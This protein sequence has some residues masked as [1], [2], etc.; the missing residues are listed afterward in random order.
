MQVIRRWLVLRFWFFTHLRFKPP[1]RLLIAPQDIRTSDPTIATDI[2]AGYFAFGGKIV[3][4]H[5]RSPFELDPSSETWVRALASFSWLRHLRAADT[6]L[7]HANARALVDDFLIMFG[8]P[9]SVP[10]WEPEVAA[11][12]MLAW[13]SQSPIILDGTDH[14][15]YR[16]FMKGL[17]K[18]QIYLQARIYEGLKG[19][20]RLL[21]ALALAEFVLCVDGPAKV[22]SRYLKIFM[23]ELEKQILPDG[24]HI[25]RNPQNLVDLLLDLLPLRQAFG[26]R[27]LQTP[28]QLLNVIDRAMPMLRLYR[29]GDGTL[30]LFHGMG[31]TLPE[32]L[33][34]VLAYDD[35]R[36]TAMTNAR[37]TG[38]QRIEA[39]DTILI[40]DT[41][42]P[43]P[44]IFSNRANASCLAF[45]FSAGNHRIII[46]C[47][48]PD[49]GRA[50]A[51]AA[52]RTSAAQSTLT[53]NDTS[54][55]R[56][57][58]QLGHWS[59]LGNQIL[60]G[61]QKVEVTRS[62]L[63]EGTEL[64]AAHDGYEER[65]GWHHQREIM[66]FENATML[67]GTDILKLKSKKKLPKHYPF[68]IRFHIHPH[69]KIR[70]LK[71]K[72]WA[73]CVLPNRRRW[74]FS[75][76]Y[77]KLSIEESIFFAAM[78][79]PRKTSQIVIEANTEQ[80][81][82]ISWSLQEIARKN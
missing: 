43:P 38:Y 6:A 15:F 21:I 9:S 59:F 77:S 54:S 42:V 20:T 18:L 49:P 57:S 33:A 74:L 40:M 60:S 13:L 26:A 72:Q 65:F 78:D 62:T 50:G 75:T 24:G 66:V 23:D 39:K 1:Q 80:T 51:L 27:G 11:R 41:G 71:N 45:E 25:S 31:V 16:R 63:T 82:R 14:A 5:G 64:S 4:A 22:Q 79:G 3:N 17:G 70:R 47:G 56:F 2:Y 28:S 76:E 81:T 58:F 53:L 55:C 46:N 35:A 67:K 34:T 52:S 10:A 29:H 7:S 48:A 44:P 69:V 61:P 73:L 12:R 37:Y 32:T 19:E 68:T 36:A 8:S 30:G